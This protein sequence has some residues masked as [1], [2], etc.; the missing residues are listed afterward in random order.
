MHRATPA[1]TSFRSYVAGGARATI[2]GVDDTKL[3]QESMG[4]FMVNEARKAIESPQNYGFTSVVMDATMDAAGKITAGAESFV[5]FMGGNRSFP[6]FGNMD[7]RRHRL[8]N[9]AKGD[10][11]MFRTAVDQLQLHLAQ[12][13]GFW[14][15]PDSK[16]LRLQLVKAQQQ[17]SQP[18]TTATGS[19]AASS[20]Q[21]QQKHG[22]QP[23]YNQ[24][25]SQ[26]IEVNGT[27]SQHVNKQHQIVL[28]DKQTGMEVNPDNNVYLGSTK[29]KGS[30]LPVV[31]QGGVLAKNVFGQVG[32]SADVDEAGRALIESSERINALERAVQALLIESSERI[33]ALERAVQ[34]LTLR[35]A[36]LEGRR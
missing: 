10:V 23:L 4:N 13:G 16:K 32:S 22:Q 11:A 7:D 6:V 19:T 5:Q 14:T 20:S 29:D 36:N 17:G 35:V 1:N 21:G 24:D 3:M 34:A 30:F 12:E 8:Q 31:L 25:S 33:N 9:L 15:G 18:Q 27:M 28:T 26:F 2:P